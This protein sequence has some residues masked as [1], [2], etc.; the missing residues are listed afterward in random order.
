MKSNERACFFKIHLQKKLPYV[1]IS[2]DRYLWTLL[3]TLGTFLNETRDILENGIEQCIIK[4]L[5]RIC[6]CQHFF[7]VRPVHFLLQPVYAFW[8]FVSEVSKTYVHNLNS[9]LPTLLLVLI[10]ISM[11]AICK[12]IVFLPKVFWRSQPH[13]NGNGSRDNYE[14]VT[15]TDAWKDVFEQLLKNLGR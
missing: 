2:I 8:Q 3:S 5:H 12:K 7:I 13:R 9:I 6:D 11:K 4:Y 1:E 15:K 14:P 10:E